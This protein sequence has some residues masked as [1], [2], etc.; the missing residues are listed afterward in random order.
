MRV[1]SSQTAGRP[2]G[3]LDALASLDLGDDRLGDRVAR[4]ERVGELL[5]VR[6]PE[7]GAIRAGGL[8]NRVALHRRRPGAAV[9][10]VLERVQVAGFRSRRSRDARRLARRV[11]MVRGQLAARLGLR[12][13]ATAGGEDDRSRHDL[14]GAL[15]R[16]EGGDPAGA[17]GPDRQEPVMGQLGAGAR[18][19]PLAKRLRDRVPRAVA[20]LEESLPRRAAAARE[21]I[22]AV[23]PCEL[24]SRPPPAS[25][26]RTA[27]RWSAGGRAPGSRCRASCASRL[28][29]ESPASRRRRTP[30]GCRP[31]LSPSCRPAASS[32]SRA[33]HA[34][35]R[36][37]PRPRTLGQRH[38]CR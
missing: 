3:R 18:L 29:R 24:D 28:R 33:R 26:S 2:S 12:E 7:D 25:G 20:D 13:A 36:G 38:R 8:G 21:P 30:P 16:V 15:L 11:R 35:P 31:E 14:R 19:E 27:P 34:R 37:R 6:V 1:V 17:R 32:S 23:R 10:V 4:P 5:A 22:A 9:R